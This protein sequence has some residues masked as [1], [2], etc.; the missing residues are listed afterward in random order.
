MENQMSKVVGR[1][2]TSREN[3]RL[4]HWLQLLDSR[5]IRKNQHC[6]F[7]GERIVREIL[8]SRPDHCLELIYPTSW[9]Q[10]LQA[11]AMVSHYVLEGQLFKTLDVFGTGAPLLVCKIPAI[12]QWDHTEAPR[13]LELVC[14]LG[15]PSN[16]GALLRT[17][18]AFGVQKVILLKEAASPFHPKSTRAASG[19]V[20][21]VDCVYGPSIEELNHNNLA[22]T[23]VALDITGNDLSG[24]PWSKNVRILIGEEGQGLPGKGFSQKAAIPMMKGMHSLN[25][26]VAASI[27]MYAYRLQHPL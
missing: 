1:P 15:D 23:I 18:Q 13:G 24:F 11:P 21:N 3:P 20:F 6:L 8:Q 12:R 14:P 22:S 2:I 10:L 4:K 27:A 16:V 25:A 7:F 17:C 19:A 5:G 26:V 9:P